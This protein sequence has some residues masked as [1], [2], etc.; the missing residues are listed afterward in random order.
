MSTF[1]VVCEIS[2][3]SIFLLYQYAL[4][5][6][7]FPKSENTDLYHCVEKLALRNGH[8]EKGSRMA[9]A[10]TYSVTRTR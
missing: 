2:H 3:S 9:L 6:S 7:A 4:V 1:T 5:H 8:L 10:Q